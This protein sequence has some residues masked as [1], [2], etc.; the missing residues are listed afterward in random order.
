[1]PLRSKLLAVPQYRARYLQH[2]RTLAEKGLTHKNLSPVIA[3]YRELIDEEVKND[4]RKRTPYEGF[5]Q[6]TSPLQENGV[7]IEGS[8]NDFIGKRHDFLMTHAE[9]KNIDAIN[10]ERL[11]VPKR[12]A[13]K[14]NTRI[15][16]AISEFLASNKRT[17]KDPQGEFEDWIELVNH[18]SKD[19]D[20]SGMHLSD[21]KDNLSKWKIPAGTQIKAGGYLVIWA[22]E[23][24][25]AEGLHANFKLSKSGEMIFLTKENT[26]VDQVEFGTQVSEVSTGR[27]SGH[28]GKL[29]KL[30]PTPGRPNQSYK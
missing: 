6:A 13:P 25:G 4:T 1:M 21:D 17:N 18:G 16:V 3:H 27:L 24:G 19:I 12:P 7:A 14:R 29:E 10:V 5:T 22:D 9:I 23:D 28:T 8:L 15:T 26:L 30:R 2:I 11:T 20:L